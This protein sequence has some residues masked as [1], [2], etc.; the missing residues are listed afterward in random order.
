MSNYINPTSDGFRQFRENKR[1]GKIHMLNLVK[2]RAKAE[3]DDGRA[4]TGAEAYRTYGQQSGPIFRRLGGQIIWSGR[5]ENLLIGPE[6]DEEW[7]IAFIAEYPSMDAF[8]DMMRDPDYQ[9]V[10]YHRTAAV[11]NSRL[12]R[13]EPTA[14]GAGFGG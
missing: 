3:Y 14:S 9:A 10:T 12:L 13:L 11:E 1:G 7:D 2:L 6:Q 8:T 4:A 5:P